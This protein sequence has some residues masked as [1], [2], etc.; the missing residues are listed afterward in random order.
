M[1]KS[2]IRC[3]QV[4]II[5][6]SVT[7]FFYCALCFI[8][9]RLIIV[10]RVNNLISLYVSLYMQLN[11]YIYFLLSLTTISVIVGTTINSCSN[12]GSDS[13]KANVCVGIYVININYQNGTDRNALT[14]KNTKNLRK[15]WKKNA[16]IIQKIKIRET[17]SE[18]ERQR[19]SERNKPKRIRNFQTGN[20]I[21]DNGTS[22]FKSYQTKAY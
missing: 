14:K 2:I 20:F 7:L 18:M 6:Y 4:G 8:F 21:P 1:Y 5:T 13:A 16:Y 17:E 10:L 12:H 15:R 19:K 9:I 22:N 11:L 3:R